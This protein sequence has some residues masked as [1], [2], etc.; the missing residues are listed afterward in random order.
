[1][2]FTIA[3]R[4]KFVSIIFVQS[5][6]IATVN[7][8]VHNFLILCDRYFSLFTLSFLSQGKHYCSHYDGAS[9]HKVN[10][11]VLTMMV[12]PLF[13]LSA[14]SHKV[15]TT[16]LTMMVRP[17]SL[18][19]LTLPMF[20]LSLASCVP[21]ATCQDE[22]YDLGNGLVSVRYPFS[23]SFVGIPCNENECRLSIE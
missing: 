2:W 6:M 22:M 8:C 16:V 7:S 19:T 9:S 18:L 5:L 17:R 10:T 15:N 23:S 13:S 21:C 1:M 4:V 11:T 3:H 12:L 14:S 20:W